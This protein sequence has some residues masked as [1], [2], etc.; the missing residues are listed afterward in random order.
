VWTQ[1]ERDRD[2]ER[3]RDRCRER[4]T[5]RHK[6]TEKHRSLGRLLETS[7]PNKNKVK[8]QMPHGRRAPFT[9]S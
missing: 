4:D 5:E 2:R 7:K 8:K 6:E 9:R 3:Q 1:T